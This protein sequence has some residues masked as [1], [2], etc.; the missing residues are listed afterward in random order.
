M[1][2]LRFITSVIIAALALSASADVTWLETTHDFGAFQEDLGPVSCQFRFVN[3]NPEPVAIVAA[4]A[5]CG[6]TTPQYPRE[7]IA[8]GDTA[9]ITVSYDPAKRRSALSGA[10]QPGSSARKRYRYDRRCRK[11]TAPDCIPRSI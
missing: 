7:A 11:R 6:C 5:S 10:V 4:R 3:T 9:V 1:K 8:P 2:T